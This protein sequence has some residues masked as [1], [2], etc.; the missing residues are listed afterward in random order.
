MTVVSDSTKTDLKWLKYLRIMILALCD[1]PK[2][3]IEILP[4]FKYCKNNQ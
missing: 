2:I 4:T 3:R 1:I